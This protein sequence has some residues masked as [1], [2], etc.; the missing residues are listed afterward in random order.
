MWINHTIPSST[1]IIGSI[2]MH[3]FYLIIFSFVFS[4]IFL[5]F[6]LLGF[7]LFSSQSISSSRPFVVVTAELM[8]VQF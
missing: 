4:H 7:N 1:D 2:Q 8:S 6:L 3:R 5:W